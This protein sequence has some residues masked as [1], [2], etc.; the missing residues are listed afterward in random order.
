MFAPTIE[1]VIKELRL[2]CNDNVE[3]PAVRIKA[4]NLLHMLEK[5]QE[6][7]HEMHQTSDANKA[8]L[9]E[10]IETLVNEQSNDIE[11][12]LLAPTPGF[13]Y[14]ENFGHTWF[15]D[16]LYHSLLAIGRVWPRNS[17]NEQ[18]APLDPITLDTISASNLFVS[19]GRYQFD[20]SALDSVP[21]TDNQYKNP[22]TGKPFSA[23]DIQ[24]I[25]LIKTLNPMIRL[26]RE[27]GLDNNPTCLDAIKG[28]CFMAQYIDRFTNKFTMALECL[29]QSNLLNEKNIVFLSKNSVAVIRGP[30]QLAAPL[31]FLHHANLLS[32][33]NQ[34]LFL[35]KFQCHSYRA[36]QWIQTLS[37]LNALNEESFAVFIQSQ[38]VPPCDIGLDSKARNLLKLYSQK[39]VLDQDMVLNILKSPSI[40]EVMSYM[41]KL[42]S[43]YN[44]KELSTY[45]SEIDHP[46]LVKIILI[47]Q[48]NEMTLKS[49]DKAGLI[50][51]LQ[52]FKA[53]MDGLLKKDFEND[54]CTGINKLKEAK[55]LTQENF[56]MLIQDPPNIAENIEKLLES[57]TAISKIRN[58]FK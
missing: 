16:V 14:Q 42:E 19:L 50:P 5:L 25:Q 18:N 12:E 36:S 27:N 32:D 7:M 31:V 33:T 54:I 1:E 11:H 4:T 30:D 9:F 56:M 6:K 37:A 57:T 35:Q 23:K 39:G 58:F 20:L 53:L 29:N 28:Y 26:L 8:S 41:D 2:F 48:R 44:R 38:R 22:V 10:E 45:L 21:R 52:N 3:N 13:H 43:P 49:L 24:A 47:M 55:L 34:Q 46:I 15:S 17:R 40:V 51:N